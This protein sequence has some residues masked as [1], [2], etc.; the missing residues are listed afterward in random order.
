MLSVSQH[1]VCKYSWGAGD[2]IKPLVALTLLLASCGGGDHQSATPQPAV[3]T[4][5]SL[6]ANVQIE[7]NQANA[8]LSCNTPYQCGDAVAFNCQ[9][10][11]DGPK[12][13]YDNLNG[14][15]VMKCGGACL[16]PDP[17]NPTSCKVCPPH[18]W[19]CSDIPYFILVG[20]IW[21][22]PRAAFSSGI[23][24]CV[25]VTRARSKLSLRHSGRRKNQ[26]IIEI[27]RPP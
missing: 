1:V 23:L 11:V 25:L 20:Y 19:T 27:D 5:S 7:Y 2:Q 6:H 26:E 24:A 4:T 22:V 15:V 8:M 10:S 14:A 12:N 9:A 18:E 13:Y 16:A 21:H 17:T 3:I